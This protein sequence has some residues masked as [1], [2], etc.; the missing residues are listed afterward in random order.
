MIVQD[1]IVVFSNMVSNVS[2]T[3]DFVPTTVT[4]TVIKPWLQTTGCES[5]H[6]KKYLLAN[7][8]IVVTTFRLDVKTG[9]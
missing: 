1:E 7:S 2:P 8:F 6:L 4:Q 9:L 5:C 3:N